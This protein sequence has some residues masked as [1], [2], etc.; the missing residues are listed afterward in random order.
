MACGGLPGRSGGARVSRRIYKYPLIIANEQAVALPFDAQFLA[1][2][3][4]HGVPV[5]WALVDP[6]RPAHLRGIRMYA[7]GDY[8]G[9]GVGTYIA[10]F[11]LGADVCHVFATNYSGGPE[12]ASNG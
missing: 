7:T 11:Q 9:A 6:E 12:E 1:V 2:Q 8:V 3:I 10:T 4:Q 5:L